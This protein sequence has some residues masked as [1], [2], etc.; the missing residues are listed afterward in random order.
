MG[1]LPLP[2][3]VDFSEFI[4]LPW[5]DKGRDAAG[6]DCWGL[7]R[8]L[9]H[10]AT[11]VWLP[12]YSEEYTTASDRE[13][14]NSLIS[15]GMA[16]WHL[17]K[18]YR[19]YDAVLMRSNGALHIGMVVDKLRMIHMPVNQTSC[20]DYLSRHAKVGFYRHELFGS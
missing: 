10:R 3:S 1:P 16:K 7:F 5:A 19:R 8:A 15:G 4:G 17:V 12:S 18:D 6:Y 20:I 9:F 11:G 14:V 13:E 2:A